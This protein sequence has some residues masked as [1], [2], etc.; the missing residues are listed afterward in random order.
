MNDPRHYPERPFLAVSAAIVHQGRVLV[1][2]RARRPAHG[3]YTFPGGVVELGETLIEAVVREVA[4][5]T[6]LAIA[7]G[8]LI[9][10]R[11]LITRDDAGRVERHYVIL[12]FVARW[13]SG[14]FTPNDEIGGGEWLTP[15]EIAPLRTTDGIAAIAATAL[16]EYGG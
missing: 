9:A 1:V 6:A 15:A 5:E 10:H 12:S 13:L 4:E 7:P 2:R 8:R 16:A 11:E 14:T 3:L